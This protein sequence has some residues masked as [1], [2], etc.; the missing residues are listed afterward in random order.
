MDMLTGAVE[1]G[2]MNINSHWDGHAK[3]RDRLAEILLEKGQDYSLCESPEGASYYRFA[4]RQVMRM[5]K[6]IDM[7][8]PFL[9][10]AE[11]RAEEAFAASKAVKN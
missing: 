5:Q 4:M 9:K 3:D 6:I 8:T 10:R 2:L 11:K 1:I 7:I